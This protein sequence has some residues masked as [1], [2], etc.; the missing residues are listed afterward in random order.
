M[1][2]A[3]GRAPG[4]D[5]VLDDPGK[6]I[7]LARAR[8]EYRDEAFWLVDVGSNPSFVNDRPA[9]TARPCRSGRARPRDPGPA[10]RPRPHGTEHE[11]RRRGNRRDGG[12]HA[13][14]SDG[15]HDGRTDGPC[16]DQAREQAG[17]DDDLGRRQQSAEVLPGCRQ[18]ARANDGWRDAGLYAGAARVR[19][20]IR[21]LE[22]ARAGD[23][24]GHALRAGGRAR[25]LRPRC[26][27][28]APAGAD[29]DGQGARVEPQG[30]DVGPHGRA[31]HADG[32]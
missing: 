21:R 8:V 6:Y 22:G 32:R 30:Q 18:R 9:G 3:I 26:H 16:H 29:R 28:G 2:G 13:A 14:R 23:H 20:R 31:V 27:R 11:A 19:D 17:H 4:N 12:R 7:S 24:G 1:G 15:R 10:A 25:T 5:L